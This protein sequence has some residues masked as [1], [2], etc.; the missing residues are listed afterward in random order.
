MLASVLEKSSSRTRGIK[1]AKVCSTKVS[2]PVF[3]SNDI[4]IEG[5]RCRWLSRSIVASSS[6]SSGTGVSSTGE[7]WCS[8]AHKYVAFTSLIIH[9]VFA[10]DFRL[11]AWTNS[12]N[13]LEIPS[14]H[15][16]AGY[17]RAIVRN[18]SSTPKFQTVLCFGHKLAGKI[19]VTSRISKL[20][21]MLSTHLWIFGVRHFD[22]VS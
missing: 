7:V 22:R 15:S 1:L 17:W 13:L 3:W 21:H 20:S 14:R 12:A 16:L 4:F 5:L 2:N 18:S 10:F 9:C 19:P 8:F 11:L 6:I